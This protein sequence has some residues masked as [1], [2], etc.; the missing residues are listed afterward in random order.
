[1]EISRI[2]IDH[3]GDVILTQVGPSVGKYLTGVG[4]PDREDYP[5]EGPS[6]A[7]FVR[8]V[9]DGEDIGWIHSCWYLRNEASTQASNAAMLAGSL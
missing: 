2:P 7:Y 3:L 4:D 8:P 6:K 5:L 9:V 1:M